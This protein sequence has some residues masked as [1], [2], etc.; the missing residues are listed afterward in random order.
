MADTGARLSVSLASDVRH[1]CPRVVAFTDLVHSILTATYR[2][3][4]SIV[5]ILQVEK[6]RLRKVCK[7]TLPGSF[8]ATI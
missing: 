5:P 1:S 6:L 8:K 3:D 2:R 7:V 4:T